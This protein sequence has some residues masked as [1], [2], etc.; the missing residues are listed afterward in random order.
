MAEYDHAILAYALVQQDAGIEG[1]R[2]R[3]QF[4]GMRL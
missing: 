3:Q 1:A 4:K 2:S